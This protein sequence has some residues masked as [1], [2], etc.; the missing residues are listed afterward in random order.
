MLA[1]SL[2]KNMKNLRMDEGNALMR[3]SRPKSAAH[4][5]GTPIAT[6]SQ[7]PKQQIGV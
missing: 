4:G 3:K 5:R 7:T 6:K 1:Y 2:N